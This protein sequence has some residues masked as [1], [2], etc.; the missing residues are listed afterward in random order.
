MMTNQLQSNANDSRKCV[1]S[2]F[3]YKLA[4]MVAAIL[5]ASGLL[6]G[7]KLV[8]DGAAWEGPLSPR[9]PALFGISGG[10]TV[11]SLTW[12]ITQLRPRRHDRAFA[13]GLALCLLV[14]VLLITVQYWRG[15][16][17]HFN[18]ASTVDAILEASMLG[19]IIAVT[20]GIFVL[21]IRTYWLQD[22]EPVM[23]IAIRSGMWLLALSCG[24]GILT[25]VLG[26]VRIAWGESYE[27]WGRAGVL[28]FP[29]GVGLHA[30]QVFP[31]AAWILL[32][33]KIRNSERLIQC[34]IVSQWLF[35]GYAMWQTGQGRDRLDWDFLGGCLL[36]AAFLFGFIPVIAVVAELCRKRLRMTKTTTD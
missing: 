36:L 13:N 27:G 7:A 19:L 15:V 23:A 3:S 25:T 30:I 8:W 21:T 6:H 10:M 26:E 17:S 33:L 2:I 18:H 34:L 20:I 24:L 31:I 35:V 4:L 28:K 1:P 12:V 22:V 16:P 29:H 32:A 9:K 11:W 5:L 14:E